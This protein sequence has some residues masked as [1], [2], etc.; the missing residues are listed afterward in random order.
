MLFRSAV[1]KVLKDPAVQE[2]FTRLGVEV[3]LMSAE[4]FNQV[5]KADWD[6]AAQI[7]KSSGARI[8]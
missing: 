5:L 8:D 6:N 1:A 3:D 7:V 2:R 4:G